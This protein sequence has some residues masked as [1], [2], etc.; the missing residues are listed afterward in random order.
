MRR[1]EYMKRLEDEL[2]SLDE[3]T[4][5]EMLENYREH[6]AAGEALGRSDEEL[7]EE[8]GDVNQAAGEILEMMSARPGTGSAKENAPGNTA[9]NGPEPG[10]Q[11][12]DNG[13]EKAEKE[14]STGEQ[15]R[16]AHKPEAEALPVKKAQ[17]EAVG[18]QEITAL[19]RPE[20]EEKAEHNHS[21]SSMDYTKPHNLA[22][23]KPYCMPAEGIRR[24][25]VSAVWADVDLRC[26]AAEY[27][28]L[29]YISN[30]GDLF[31][32]GWVIDCSLRD[33]ELLVEVKHKLRTVMSAFNL[34]GRICIE[35]PLKLYAAAELTSVSGDTRISILKSR[36]LSISS[37]SGDISVTDV[38][39][40]S[41]KM[42]AVSGDCK[43]DYVTGR[44]ISLASVSGDAI[45]QAVET[46]ILNIQ[47]VSGDVKAYGNFARIAASAVSGDVSVENRS[48][49]SIEASTVSGDVEIAPEQSLEGSV[50]TTSGDVEIRISGQNVGLTADLSSMSGTLKSRNDAVSVIKTGRRSY[51][52]VC[53]NGSR[54]M[55]VHTMSGDLVIR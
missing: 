30:R 16:P 7:C 40:E 48:S 51:R 55:D 43:M 10:G 38:Q 35:L 29:R 12:P 19:F 50:S 27:A 45:A 2:S 47:S 46:E 5:N 14:P 34:S 33:G 18:L 54:H 4:K 26:S 36:N 8:L 20:T 39:T 15:D 22:D 25:R 32:K 9:N 13:E 6:F 42:N 21:Q 49:C 3:E 53:G 23:E 11:L 31:T 24:I 44:E 41:A 52:A 17:E 37:T 1:D 28:Q